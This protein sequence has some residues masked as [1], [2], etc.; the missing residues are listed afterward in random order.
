M[1]TLP[2]IFPGGG[3]REECASPDLE[4]RE[5]FTKGSLGDGAEWGLEGGRALLGS[6]GSSRGAKPCTHA[7]VH[8]PNSVGKVL[9]K[10]HPALSPGLSCLSRMEG[11]HGLSRPSWR[12]DARNKPS[13]SENSFRKFSFWMDS[14]DF[15]LITKWQPCVQ[16]QPERHTQRSH[17]QGGPAAKPF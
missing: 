17:T 4:T 13:S 14:L 1:E 11:A 16:V 6:V 2:Q 3:F 15:E 7:T 8:G 5:G 10:G 12:N 9:V